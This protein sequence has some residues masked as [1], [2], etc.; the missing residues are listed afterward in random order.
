MVLQLSSASNKHSELSVPRTEV[1]LV[2]AQPSFMLPLNPAGTKTS[3]SRVRW[4]E[5]VLFVVHT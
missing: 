2:V 3:E 4:R 5:D 1:A